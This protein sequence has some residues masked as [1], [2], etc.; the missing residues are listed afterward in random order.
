M[1]IAATYGHINDMVDIELIKLINFVIV[2]NSNFEDQIEVS[3]EIKSMQLSQLAQDLGLL[4]EEDSLPK[5]DQLNKL[6]WS[7]ILKL[8]EQVADTTVPMSFFIG[9]NPIAAEL[10]RKHGFELQIIKFYDKLPDLK[11][12]LEERFVKQTNE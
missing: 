6:D 5:L 3:V 2:S 4:D 1:D 11:V 9:F 12:Q 7:I 10:Y 8:L